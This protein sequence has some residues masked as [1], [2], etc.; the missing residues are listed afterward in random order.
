MKT[1][2]ITLKAG[3]T[4]KTAKKDIFL[5]VIK[6]HGTGFMV[7]VLDNDHEVEYEIFMAKK[8]IIEFGAVELVDKK[9][10]TKINKAELAIIS[11]VRQL[12]SS[13]D[14]KVDSS[15]IEVDGLNK[16]QV[17]GHISI[18]DKKGLLTLE[19]KTSKKK[20]ISESAFS[21]TIFSKI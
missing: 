11:K 14:G 8:D 3:Q 1:E 6:K 13:H 15:G 19:K 4:F 2:N 12:E 18:L 7:A 9:H 10:R 16:F 20:M 5:K 17:A 21:R